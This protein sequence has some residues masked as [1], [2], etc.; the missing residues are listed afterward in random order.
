MGRWWLY[1]GHWLN[2]TSQQ[3]SLYHWG[4]RCLVLSNQR[5]INVDKMGHLIQGPRQQ[6]QGPIQRHFG[7]SFACRVYFLRKS[8]EFHDI[9]TECQIINTYHSFLTVLII[10]HKYPGISQSL[11]PRSLKKRSLIISL[12]LPGLLNICC[13]ISYFSQKLQTL[14]LIQR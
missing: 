10:S 7:P 12:L 5:P 3:N 9:H 6:I 14:T 1:L 2:I 4:C 13:Q 11:A 8:I